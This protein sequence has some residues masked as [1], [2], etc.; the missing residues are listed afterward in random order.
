MSTWVS[1]KRVARYGLVGFFRNGFV[2]LAA[3][4]IMT[5]TLFVIAGLMLANAALSATLQL[6][7]EKV[8][9]N[10]YFTLDAPEE[11]VLQ[12]RDALEE[13]P[14]VESVTYISPEEALENFRERHQNDQL[15]IQAL[16]ELENNP[17]GASL[18]VRAGDTSQY[19]SI[20]SYLE[21]APVVGSGDERI[22]EKVN[23]Y[24]NQEAIERL[25]EIIETSRRLGIAISI[26]LG[27]AS[28]MIA[29]NTIRL[30]IYTSR[31]EIGVMRLVGA[32][33]WYVRGPFVVSGVLYGLASALI[34]LV[35]M[36][37]ISLWLGGPSSRFFGGAF[38]TASYY[39][40]SFF[41]IFFAIVGM[42]ILLGALSSYLAVRRYLRE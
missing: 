34:V 8:D 13:L 27:I 33:P 41:T 35:L 9:V 21:T 14:E 23:Y 37:P 24:Q 12:V 19:E 32:G 3:M 29:F 18:A 16:E 31:E 42:G 20:A 28:L 4:L 10:V 5:I 26:I 38:D 25:S 6:L 2:S 11:R 22:V 30:A 40:G 15:T 39:A 17:L 1:I 7:T 36:Y